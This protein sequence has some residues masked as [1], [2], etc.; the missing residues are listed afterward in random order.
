MRLN[1]KPKTELSS[2]IESLRFCNGRTEPI[3]DYSNSLQLGWIIKEMVRGEKILAYK[4][5]ET[6]S[7]KIA[8]IFLHTQKPHTFRWK[9]RHPCLTAWKWEE[10]R[11]EHMV[12]LNKEIWQWD[13]HMSFTTEHLSPVL[14][15]VADRELRKKQHSLEWLFHTKVFQAFSGLLCSTATSLFASCLCY[16]L[17]QHIAWHPHPYSQRTEATIQNWLNCLSY[18]F[19][20]FSMY[21]KVLLKINPDYLLSL[22]AP[23]C[24]T[25]QWYPE[26][27][28]LFCQGNSVASTRKNSDKSK[29]YCL[30]IDGGEIVGTSGLVSFRKTL[31]NEGISEN[32][33]HIIKNS[34]KNYTLS[35][36]EPAWTK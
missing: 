23:V 11:N 26:L 1:T 31:L 8:S 13:H 30:P 17:P 24:T 27:L 3:D 25:Q 2:W 36:C 18:T 15:K 29:K 5:Y 22:I 9:T 34:R 12:K 28:N 6:T 14:N 4:C 19:P 16:Q 10:Q 32:A 35:K 7:N 21:S 33:S 20:A